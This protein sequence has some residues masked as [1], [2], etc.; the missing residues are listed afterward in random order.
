[1]AC[2]AQKTEILPSLQVE[3]AI[4]ICHKGQSDGETEMRRLIAFVLTLLMPIMLIA[5]GGTLAGWGMTNNWDWLVWAGLSMIAVGV[6]WGIALFLW[7][8]NGSI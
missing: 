3:R 2:P 6:L 1:M 7:A 4:A 8:G 5:G